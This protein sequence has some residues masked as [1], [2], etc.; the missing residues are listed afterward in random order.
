MHSLDEM[1]KRLPA[2]LRAEVM[3]FVEF[4]LARE[5]RKHRPKMTCDWAAGLEDLRAEYTSV[6]LQHRASEWRA[7]NEISG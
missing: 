6:E 1:V 7:E 5:S 4:L 3:D 2:G